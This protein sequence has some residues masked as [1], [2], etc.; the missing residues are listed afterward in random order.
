[1][2]CTTHLCV[3]VKKRVYIFSI[4]IVASVVENAKKK[5]KDFVL[6]TKERNI[7]KEKKL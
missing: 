6:R 4:A 2:F 3:K 7:K 1:M 5:E